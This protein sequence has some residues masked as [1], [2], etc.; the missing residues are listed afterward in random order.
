MV[1]RDIVLPVDPDTAWEAL[2]DD[3]LRREWLGEAAERETV[4]EESEPGE[5]L[6]FWW[7]EGEEPGSRVEVVLTPIVG[8]TRVSVTESV[9]GP[10]ACSDFVGALGVRFA[11]APVLCSGF[12]GALR[13]HFAQQSSRV[14]VA[15]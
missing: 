12:A 1:A 7:W 8:G 3:D 15:A 13:A 6:V 14:L 10:F 4:V 9:A 11:N 2:T 5:R